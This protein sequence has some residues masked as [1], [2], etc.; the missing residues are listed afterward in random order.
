[1]VNNN[2]VGIYVEFVIKEF[3]HL[4][5]SI[6]TPSLPHTRCGK[7]EESSATDCDLAEKEFISYSKKNNATPED[8][9]N[10]QKQPCDPAVICSV[11]SSTHCTSV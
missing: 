5:Q 3:N 4:F 9:A 7:Q 2:P 8:G 1:M 6:A 10:I 11:C